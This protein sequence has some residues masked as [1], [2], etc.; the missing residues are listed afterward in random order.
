MSKSVVP[1]LSPANQVTVRLIVWPVWIAE[2]IGGPV[3]YKKMIVKPMT[4][5][6]IVD[7]KVPN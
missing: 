3:K 1:T 7:D 6:Y 2:Q 5:Y 4:S